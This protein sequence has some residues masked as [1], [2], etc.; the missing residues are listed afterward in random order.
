LPAGKVEQICTTSLFPGQHWQFAIVVQHCGVDEV[1]H[2]AP[3]EKYK[4][5]ALKNLAA[6]VQEEQVGRLDLLVRDMCELPRSQVRG[7]LDH[8]CVSINGAT[9]TD[10]GHQIVVG[11]EV[12]ISLDPHRRYKEIKRKWDDRTFE[13]VHEDDLIIVVNKAAGTLTVPTG[14][15]EPNTLVERVSMYLNHSKRNKAAWVVHRLD[16]DV[17]GLLTFAK[18]E[19]VAKAMI[20]HFKQEKP[21]R[22]YTAIV[23]GVIAQDEGEFTSTIFPDKKTRRPQSTQTKTSESTTATTRYKVLQRGT[24]ATVVQMELD[25]GVRHQIRTH[26]ADAGHRVLGDKQFGTEASPHPRWVRKRL[27][28]HA[29][30]LSFAHPHTGETVAYESPLPAAFIKFISGMNHKVG[31]KSK[32]LSPWDTAK[33]TEGKPEA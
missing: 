11:D 7:V 24:D 29:R 16:R 8:G 4:S 1:R 30:T 17:S 23:S 10:A 12:K 33:K 19:P 13:I 14:K 6:T 20:E 26:F 9:I 21:V 22:S 3:V 32:P 15:D 27:A 5:M 28:L 2:L 18:H 25:S 31:A